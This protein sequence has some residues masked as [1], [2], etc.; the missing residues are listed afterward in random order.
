MSRVLHYDKYGRQLRD[1]NAGETHSVIGT[2]GTVVRCLTGLAWVTQEG[3]P[4]DR[5]LPVGA[6]Y[7]SGSRGRIV[8][9][10]IDDGT[11]IAVYKVEPVPAADWTHNR[12]SIGA[13]FAEQLR[14]AA[15]EEMARWFA[16][17]LLSG[18]RGGQR[19]WRRIRQYLRPRVALRSG[20]RGYHS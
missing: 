4:L 17:L 1:L 5:V 14:R 15:R 6:R 8:V 3:D 13:D 10:A 20:F 16:A 12:I 19:A 9:S 18:W 11:R 7:C 2:R